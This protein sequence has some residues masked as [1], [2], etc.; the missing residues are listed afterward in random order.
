MISYK[1]LNWAECPVAV[2]A[3]VGCKSGIKVVGKSFADI[4]QSCG[5]DPTEYKEYDSPIFEIYLVAAPAGCMV[6]PPPFYTAQM[7]TFDTLD[8]HRVLREILLYR[9][10]RGEK[11]FSPSMELGHKF[12][13]AEGL[14]YG[15]DPNKRYF[16]VH[17]LIEYGETTSLTASYGD[18]LEDVQFFFE[19]I[20]LRDKFITMIST[21]ASKMMNDV[22]VEYRS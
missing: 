9:Q 21:Y 3:N 22:K 14:V 11:Y 15:I 13:E 20:T 16:V 12:S 8:G 7:P 19:D 10:Y 18:K 1:G 5:Y 4:A 6:T 17:A 2:A